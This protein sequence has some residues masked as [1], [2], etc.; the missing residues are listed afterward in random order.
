MFGREK[1]LAAPQCS[2]RP[3]GEDHVALQLTNSLEE[4]WA[5]ELGYE[6]TPDTRY[7]AGL[8]LNTEVSPVS[9]IRALFLQGARCH[10]SGNKES[11][12]F[13]AADM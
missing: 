8:R 2:S 1:L 9:G 11:G 7:T 10:L 13:K 6:E 3:L 4:V 5:N 12:G